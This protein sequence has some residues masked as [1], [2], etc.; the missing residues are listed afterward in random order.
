MASRIPARSWVFET[1]WNAQKGQAEIKYDPSYLLAG[2]PSLY[3]L[4]NGAY[5]LPLGTL[6]IQETK[7][8]IGYELD[9]QVYVRQIIANPS[10]TNPDL[11]SW[12]KE[13]WSHDR[14]HR[15][16]ISLS[17]YSEEATR[18]SSLSRPLSGVQFE[19][20]DDNR[21]NADGAT[22]N[23]YG[24]VLCV[25]TT[26]SDGFASTK[27]LQG[28]NYQG[29]F[30]ERDANWDGLLAFGSYRVREVPGSLP[31][32]YAPLDEEVKIEITSPG[33]TRHIIVQNTNLTPLQ[34]IK[35]ASDTDKP[36]G[37]SP[38][39]F[40]LLDADKKPIEFR[41]LERGRW[42]VQDIFET[43]DD[44][45][46]IL[47]ERIPAGNYFLSEVQA[48]EGYLINPELIP[49]KAV[50]SSNG[51]ATMIEVIASN[52]LVKGTISLRKLDEKNGASIA[53]TRFEIIAAEDIF[54]ADGT[55]RAT[56]GEVVGGFITDDEGMATSD[57]LHIGSYL[58]REVESSPGYVLDASTEHLV[59][60]SYAD[61]YTEIVI[62][63]L[64]VFNRRNQLVLRKIEMGSEKRLPGVSF[65]LR[66]LTTSLEETTAPAEVL[67]R[68]TTV[69]NE[70]GEIVFEGLA[71]GSYELQELRAL[72]GYIL[73]S[74]VYPFE[75]TSD[76]L[77]EGSDKHFIIV[78]NAV[79]PKIPVT[80]V[81]PPAA[82][83][84]APEPAQKKPLKKAVGREIQMAKAGD[85]LHILLIVSLASLACTGASFLVHQKR[86]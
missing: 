15:G 43:S 30:I 42:V 60:L 2:Q 74:R 62:E 37:G 81:D 58:V 73:N 11:N 1:K 55:L 7:A 45:S 4:S 56:K 61:Q 59:S 22:N 72:P 26:N 28:Y 64:E 75:V 33:I 51:W 39:K 10:S 48:P 12:G 68:E 85:S 35:I 13:V 53:G 70:S 66:R 47:P 21:Q 18:G 69:T 41:F 29:T 71:P 14:V 84:A 31:E 16:D 32:G 79:I 83:Q 52:E 67:S 9:P 78:E 76:G 80:P 5:R 49:V 24:K 36:I 34:V 20:I 46:F 3:A 82:P 40:R 65:E 77:I 8:P 86:K 17:K 27:D 38:M 6:T 19:I 63:E 44:G 54:T 23:N 57:D 50:G 25:L